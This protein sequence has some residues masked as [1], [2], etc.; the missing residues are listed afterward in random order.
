[1]FANPFKVNKEYYFSAKSN[2]DHIQL[3]Q[4]FEKKTSIDNFLRTD[5]WD[6]D[7]LKKQICHVNKD[8]YLKKKIYDDDLFKGEDAG[9]MEE[10][11]VVEISFMKAK[12]K[13]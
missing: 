1:M 4:V 8:V 3:N 10:K 11:D 13:V 6:E 12:F 7:K 9:V 2:R 5:S